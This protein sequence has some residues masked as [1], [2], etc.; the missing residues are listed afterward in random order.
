[1][2]ATNCIP[3]NRSLIPVRFV[4]TLQ[5][6]PERV[7]VPAIEPGDILLVGEPDNGNGDRD[8]REAG[9]SE[10][11]EPELQFPPDQVGNHDHGK[12]GEQGSGGEKAYKHP[13]PADIAESQP[14]IGFKRAPDILPVYPPHPSV[15]LQVDPGGENHREDTDHLPSISAI[16][17]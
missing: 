1:M 15:E 8:H 11:D 13:D 16:S 5:G 12:P 9:G 3:G 7:Q 10:N 2:K 6:F 14:D 17:S 4:K